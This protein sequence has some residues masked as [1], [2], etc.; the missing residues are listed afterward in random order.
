MSD[1]RNL[2]IAVVLS[3][4][5]VFGW[6][7][8]VGVPKM[9]QEQAKQAQTL[10][11]QKLNPAATQ[12]GAASVAQAGVGVPRADALAKSSQRASIDTP[13]LAG[14]INLTGGRFDDLRLRTYHE[15]PDPKS[16]EIELLSPLGSEHPYFAEFGWI[17]PEGSRQMA[18]V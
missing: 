2:L 10:Q 18:P 5:V 8:L 12:P 17:A 14:S 3:M 11:Q 1:Q 7:Y 4:V 15:T 9:Q 6:Q 13:K 16:P